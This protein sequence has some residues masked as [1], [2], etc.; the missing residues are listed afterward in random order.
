[1]SAFDRRQFLRLAGV[2]GVVLVPGLAGVSGMA[3]AAD[4]MGTAGYDDFYFVQLSDSHWGFEGPPNPDATGTLPKAIASV[5]ALAAGARLRRLH[6]RPHPHHRRPARAPQAHGRSSRHRR[7][8]EGEGR[9]L[10]ARRARRRPRQ[11]QGLHGILRPDPLHLR[12][13]GRALHRPRQRQRPGRAARRSAARLA[14]R[15]PR[16]SRP[17]TRASS[18]SRIGR[19]STSTRNGTGPRATAP[20]PSTCC[21]PY[22][23]VT[24]FYGHIHQ[25]NHHMTGHIAHHSAKSLIFA[26]P[27]AGSQP[28]RT[29]GAVGSGAAVRG[30]GLSRGRGRE[31][32]ERLHDHRASCSKGLMQ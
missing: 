7:R 4:A 30:P 26:L 6:R 22:S 31:E 1:M 20:R 13:Q 9:A 8:P 2:G 5:N 11:R 29:A 27:V 17:R 24:V 10:H 14:R 15:R 23:N 28:K 12:A 19:C 32:A 21:M 18:S 16:A 25:E 3:H